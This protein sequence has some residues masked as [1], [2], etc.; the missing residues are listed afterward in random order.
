MFPESFRFEKTNLPNP[1]GA[2]PL[3]RGHTGHQ[4]AC[5]VDKQK[6]NTE[7]LRKIADLNPPTC[8]WGPSLQCRQ[9]TKKRRTTTNLGIDRGCG[10]NEEQVREL[11]NAVSKKKNLLKNL[12]RAERAE[13]AVGY[14]KNG[15]LEIPLENLKGSGWGMT[16]RLVGR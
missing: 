7:K 12:L 10:Q 3:H 14:T 2:T 1:Q 6:A 11:A 4:P 16:K 15:P 13:E 8:Q 9:S 5:K